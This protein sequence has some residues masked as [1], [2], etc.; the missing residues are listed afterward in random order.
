MAATLMPYQLFNCY[1]STVQSYVATATS[2]NTVIAYQ[3][4]FF[5]TSA[6]IQCQVW[7]T[8]TQTVCYQE[9]K[10]QREER[11]QRE[12]DYAAKE[13]VRRKCATEALKSLLDDTQRGQFEKENHFEL[14]VNER[15]YRITPG[16]RVQRLNPQTKEVE[17]FFCIHPDHIHGL[18]AED[19]A[20]GQKLL[21]EANEAEFLRVA[22]ETKAA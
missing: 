5:I 19:V 17:S 9:T 20:I 13:A 12:R 21:L 7:P 10:E 22:N 14:Q 8:I 6:T 18:P 16:T 15:L 2:A 4:T 3:Q 11:E 1:G